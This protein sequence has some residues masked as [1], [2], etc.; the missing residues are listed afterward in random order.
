MIGDDP[1]HPGNLGTFVTRC[2]QEE[3]SRPKIEVRH[4]H[5]ARP[6]RPALA[7]FDRPE[8]LRENTP[9]PADLQI[10]ALLVVGGLLAGLMVGLTG[11]GGAA[12]VTPMLI[13]VFGV[14]APVA[15][16]TDVASMAVIKPV[17]ASVHVR[18]RTPHFRIAFW[19]CVGSVPG[20]L[21]GTLW[22]RSI[23]TTQNGSTILRFLV[24]VA[25]LSSVLLSFGRLRLRRFAAANAHKRIYLSARR[26]AAVAI[27]GAVIGVMVGLTSVG[28]GSLIAAA[29]V[30]LFPSMRPSRLVGTDL[31]QAVPMLIVGAL[32]HWGLGEIDGAVM[33]S[34]L[35]GQLPGIWIGARIS[36]HYDGQALRLLVLIFIATAGLALIGLPA[37][38]V[39]TI[40]IAG[41][42]LIGVPIIRGYFRDR[43]RPTAE[44][45][46]GAE[47]EELSEPQPGQQPG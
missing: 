43:S 1:R 5:R 47:T 46:G 36:S 45:D 42:V 29:L 10:N 34:L 32:A 23:A 14:P 15:V 30:L 41:T 7:Q 17:G 20:V 13:F 9:V 26:R 3:A 39:T 11:M 22:F 19:L 38:A 37:W 6:I 21:I 35:L 27:V 33:L 31:V 2:N 8:G 18:Q 44:P 16:S 4:R 12:V 25:L 28:S 40:T 24:G